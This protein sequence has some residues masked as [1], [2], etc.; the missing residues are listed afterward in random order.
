M[1]RL[2]R[3]GVKDD[4]LGS[5][6]DKLGGAIA[7]KNVS[8]LDVKVRVLLWVLPTDANSANI[9]CSN[10]STGQHSSRHSRQA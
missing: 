6:L 2:K 5:F 1:Q 8:T 3:E 7:G 9:A 4:E 10:T